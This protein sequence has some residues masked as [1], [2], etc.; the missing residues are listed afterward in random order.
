[1]AS[2]YLDQLREHGLSGA[3]ALVETVAAIENCS[4]RSIAIGG[5]L[6]DAEEEFLWLERFVS[7]APYK[8]SIEDVERFD[9]RCL[10]VACVLGKS[11][12]GPTLSLNEL[13][14]L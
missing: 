7:G 1:M 8:L 6:F 14:L 9:Q 4:G 12:G 10:I 11:R 5:S 3:V 2:K 13:S